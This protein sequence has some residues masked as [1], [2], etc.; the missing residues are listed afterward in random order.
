M[1]KFAVL[2]IYASA[3]TDKRVTNEGKLKFRTLADA[4]RRA[5]RVRKVRVMDDEFRG[6]R[7]KRNGKRILG[8]SRALRTKPAVARRGPRP[9][10][11]LIRSGSRRA[12]GALA[13]FAYGRL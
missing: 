2:E 9:R 4:G 8:D 13:E 6:P 11:P 3:C 5:R 1:N 12:S 7:P 10:P